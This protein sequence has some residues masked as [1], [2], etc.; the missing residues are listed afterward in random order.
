[1][2]EWQDYTKDELL[3]LPQRDWNIT[4][5]YDSV[6]FVPTAMAHDSGFNLF[7][8]VGCNGYKPKEIVGYMDDFRFDCFSKNKNF[9]DE[10]ISSDIAFDCSMN[11]VFRMHTRRKI[12]VGCNVSTTNWWLEDDER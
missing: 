1:M 10:I 6:L 2:K 11:G 8:V 3:Q 7:A 4:T 5:K 9:R 12:C